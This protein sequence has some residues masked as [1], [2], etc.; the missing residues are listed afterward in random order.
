MDGDLRAGLW[1]VFHPL[2]VGP[3]NAATKEMR[4][5]PRAKMRMI[6]DELF[7]EPADQ[8]PQG[9][10]SATETFKPLFLQGNYLDVY[11]LIDFTVQAFG[12]SFG[13]L[14]SE[15]NRTLERE[16]SG[17]RFVN[18]VL[19]PI[20]N[21]YEL[22]AI[23][24]GLATG[25]KLVGAAAHL[26][27]ALDL[28]SD[29]SD[30][31][32]RNSVKESISAVESAARVVS[33]KPK[34]SLGDL[35]PILKKAG[36]LHPAQAEAFSKLYGYTSDEQGIRHAILDESRVDFADAKYMLVVCAAFVA[37][38]RAVGVGS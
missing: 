29:R 13:S 1:N 2:F 14:E 37:Y 3:L 16:V 32:Y 24:E 10:G 35:L 4:R 27:T 15:Y 25:D 12:S 33:G 22:A 19:S 23:E 9:G 18:G 34:A 21:E 31:D 8:A 36:H 30:P 17:Y 5:R 7:K 11:D 20:S 6:W 28:L 26:Q 38:L